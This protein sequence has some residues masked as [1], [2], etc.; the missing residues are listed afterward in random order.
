VLVI[1]DHGLFYVK[2][3]QQFNRNAGILSRDKIA[4]FQRIYP[5][6]RKIP[7]IANGRTHDDKLS[8]H[9]IRP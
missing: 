2:T 9:E 6:G 3:V 5:P 1:A 8:A 7:Q 4:L